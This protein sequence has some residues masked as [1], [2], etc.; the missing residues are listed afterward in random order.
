MLDNDDVI[1]GNTSVA[2]EKIPTDEK[3]ACESLQ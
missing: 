2:V 3:D 1:S